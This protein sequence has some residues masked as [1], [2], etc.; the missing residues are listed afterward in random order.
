SSLGTGTATVTLE[1][2]EHADLFF[3]IGGNPASNHPRLMT[4]LSKIRKRCG[5]IIVINPVIETGLV[6]FRVP[7]D[8]WSLL[9]GTKI[10]TQY[11]QPHIGGDLALLTGVAKRI[12]EMGAQDE[13]FLRQN[14]AGYDEW[15]ANLRRIP[16]SEIHAKS[17]VLQPGIDQIAETYAA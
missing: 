1:D 12:D 9:F 8:P 13:A 3:L 4:T 5:Q 15:I 17:G 14:C 7:S 16:W 10:A 11:V 6:N 2:V